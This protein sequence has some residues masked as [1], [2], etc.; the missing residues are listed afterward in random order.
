MLTLFTDEEIKLRRDLVTSPRF[1]PRQWQTGQEW[2]VGDVNIPG[3]VNSV[4]HGTGDWQGW[5]TWGRTGS[6][7][8]E[9]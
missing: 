4:S 2:E 9:G 3:G 8:R 1:W 7:S 6:W 5:H